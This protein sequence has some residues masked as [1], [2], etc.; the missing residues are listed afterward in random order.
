[1]PIIVL[2]IL[3][4]CVQEQQTT[5]NCGA[6]PEDQQDKCCAE[7]MKG[8]PHIMCVGE[9]KWDEQAGCKYECTTTQEKIT[10][11]EECVAAGHPV[12]ES[13]PEQ[14]SDGI[15]TFVADMPE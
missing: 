7:Q 9:W 12:M 8:K 14:C 2:L 5:D 1:M 11:F 15:N 3:T 4:G 10:T 6:L 13:Y